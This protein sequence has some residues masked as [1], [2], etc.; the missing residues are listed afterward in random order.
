MS[1]NGSGAVNVDVAVIDTGISAHPDLNVVGGVNCSTGKSY[2][3]GN[4]H[5]SHV[6][7]TIGAKDDSVGVVGVA[8]GAR[9]WA[10]RV[11]N[12]QGSGTRSGDHLRHRLGDRDARRPSRSPT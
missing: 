7:G 9:L 8:P 2:D 12:N 1:G 5:G 6:A 4:G 11:L 3:D 10:V